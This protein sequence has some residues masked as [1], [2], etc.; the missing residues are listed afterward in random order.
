MSTRELLDKYV[1]PFTITVMLTLAAV[2][3]AVAQEET[4]LPRATI[5]PSI[6]RSAPGQRQWFK[7][8]KQATR[9]NAAQWMQDVKWAVNGIPGGNAE[10]GTIAEDGVYTAPE[11]AP[12]VREIVIC[13]EVEGVANRRL[14]AT[15]L[16]EAPGPPYALVKSWGESREDA[17]HFVD[18]HC[19]A[20]DG[21]G[22][23]MIADYL[24]SKVTRFTPDGEFLGIIGEGTGEAP[25]KVTKPRVVT[26][27]PN[28]L[29]FVSDQKSDKPRIQVFTPEGEFLRIFAPKGTGPGHL[30]RAHGMAFD[31]DLNLYVID[32]DNMRVNVYAHDGTFIK[33]WGRD[34][35]RV[36]EF[37]APHGLVVDPNNDVFVC[38]YYG[39]CRKFNCDGEFLFAFAHG[40]PP[41]GAVYIHSAAGDRWG[42]VY[43]MVRGA[44]GYGG[45]IEEQQDE[46]PSIMKFNNNGDHVASITLEVSGHK[47]NWAAVDKDGNVYAVYES[48]EGFGV[49]IYEPR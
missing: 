7:I 3:A 41:D 33:S 6:V 30:L 40:D 16:F 26:T 2:S 24:G 38:G 39:T 35:H 42:N 9:L 18:P 4:W 34:G 46:L 37:N 47:E 31:E 27:D 44:R 5:H 25:G 12:R 8:V 32:V 49:Q 43:L 48:N 23:I 11:K 1:R 15:V 28:G 22:N 36:D 29:I 21:D 13:A 45:A 19:V 10:I 14:W 20:L 17:E